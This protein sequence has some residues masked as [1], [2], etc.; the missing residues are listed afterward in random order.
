MN[1]V[2]NL[3]PI[4]RGFDDP[5]FA[6][7]LAGLKDGAA[8]FAEFTRT[9]DGMDALEGLKAGTAH[10][11]KLFA[12]GN[13]L[14]EYCM[15]RQAAN[16]LDPEANSNAGQAMAVLSTIAGP[17]AVYKEW[18]SRLPN[19]MELVAGDEVLRE[20]TF[21]YS[22]IRESS[23]YLLPG[24]GEEIMAK[25]ELSGGSAWGDLQQYLTSTVAVTYRGEKTNLSSIRN[26]AYDP[27][28][29][30]RKDAYEAELACY[31]QI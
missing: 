26:L 31:K 13:K 15:L 24:R 25:M 22:T 14:V 3:D 1:D 16:T 4:Y 27:D 10:L 7:D 21:L 20:Y 12:Y 2:W 9:L 18:A 19:L 23:V 5:A 17:K 28:G 29:A 11:E 6:A 30:V 8:E